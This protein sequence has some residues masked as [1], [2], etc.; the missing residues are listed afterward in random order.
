VGCC[1]FALD[2]LLDEA[3]AMPTWYWLQADRRGLAASAPVSRMK[4]VVAEE[5]AAACLDVEILGRQ[6]DMPNAFVKIPP[7]A[8]PTKHRRSQQPGHCCSCCTAINSNP[9]K[10][11]NKPYQQ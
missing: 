1:S 3:E 4:V 7:P 11:T 2:Q 6:P 5:T 9:N 8:S 10:K